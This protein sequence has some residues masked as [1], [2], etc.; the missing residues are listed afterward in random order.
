[1]EIT[2]DGWSQEVIGGILSVHVCLGSPVKETLLSE[3]GGAR[4]QILLVGYDKII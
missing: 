3:V 2:V 1:M 4:L